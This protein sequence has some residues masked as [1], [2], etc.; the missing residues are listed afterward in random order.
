LS[1]LMLT[2]LDL[3]EEADLRTVTV[4]SCPNLSDVSTLRTKGELTSINLKSCSPDIDLSGLFELPNLTKFSLTQ[5]DYD[6]FDEL[7]VATSLERLVLDRTKIADLYPLSTLSNLETLSLDSSEGL[8]DLEP[9][10]GLSQLKSLSLMGCLGL[11]DLAPL[12]DLSELTSLD[13][14]MCRNISSLT[15][16]EALPNLEHV[17][18]RGCGPDIDPTPLRDRGVT[19]LTGQPILARLNARLRSV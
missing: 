7:A 11:S 8:A 6:G 16:L 15:S 4:R 12:S 1:E 5:A 3:A 18:A 2:D 9:L 17:D 10:V 19:V 13:L 14:E